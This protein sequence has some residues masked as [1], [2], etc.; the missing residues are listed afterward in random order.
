LTFLVYGLLCF[1][2]LL[3]YIGVNN[4]AKDM[5]AS[6]NPNFTQNPMVNP[7]GGDYSYGNNDTNDGNQNNI[8][9]ISSAINPLVMDSNYYYQPSESHQDSNGSFNP[10]SK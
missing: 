4:Y 3:A 6:Q 8:P 7:E 2:A 1:A 9:E 10:T 5:I